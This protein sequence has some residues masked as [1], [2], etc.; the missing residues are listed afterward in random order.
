MAEVREPADAPRISADAAGKEAAL[1]GNGAG[2]VY[3]V[4]PRGEPRV[5]SAARR[6]APGQVLRVRVA[7]GAA[8][9]RASGVLAPRPGL[10]RVQLDQRGR[11]REFRA[12]LHAPGRRAP[13]GGA[14]EPDHGAA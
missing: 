14:L 6:S 3:R 12:G 1:H 13:L 9:S 10:G 7:T 4:E 11:S 5:E 8:V 2:S